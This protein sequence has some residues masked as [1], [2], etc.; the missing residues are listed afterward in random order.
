MDEPVW[1]MI[2]T[3]HGAES[4]HMDLPDGSLLRVA[5]TPHGWTAICADRAGRVLF[6]AW[7]DAT[8]I[9]DALSEAWEL[10]CQS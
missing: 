3:V 9:E 5:E 2:E 10:V 6:T 7:L 8:E 4:A 1:Q